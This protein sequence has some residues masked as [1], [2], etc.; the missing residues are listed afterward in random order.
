MAQTRSSLNNVRIEVGR[1]LDVDIENYAVSVRSEHSEQPAHWIPLISPFSEQATG[2]GMKYQPAVGET[3]LMLT[4]SD[5]YRCVLGFIPVQENGSLSGGLP[6]MNGGDFFTI[7][8]NG[9]FIKMHAG[10]VVEIGATPIASTVYIPIR[11]LV[12]TIGENIILDSLAGSLEFSVGR[13][14]DSSKGNSP[15]NME[16]KIKEFSNDTNEITRIKAGNGLAF[17]ITVKDSGNG[18]NIKAVIEL[19]KEGDLKISL[20]KNMSINIKGKC[21]VSVTGDI[22]ID[23]KGSINLTALGSSKIQ[24]GPLTITSTGNIDVNNINTNINSALTKI[25]PAAAFP[26]V[27]LSPELIYNLTVL[28]VISGVPLTS[29]HFNPQVLV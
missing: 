17:G 1:I 25:S 24:T 22:N 19:T 9:S 8:R 26:V 3:V 5:G 12:H 2:A 6:P 14:D 15:T 21:D 4:T 27:R 16:I 28:G 13:E 20:T 29:T 11:N 18:E 23:S 10:G 7:N